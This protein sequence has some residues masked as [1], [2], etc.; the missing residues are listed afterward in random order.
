LQTPPW[1]YLTLGD[2]ALYFEDPDFV[3]L[4]DLVRLLASDSRVHPEVQQRANAVVQHLATCVLSSGSLGGSSGIIEA[5][6][7]SIYFPYMAYVRK[8]GDLAFASATH[9]DELVQYLA[10]WR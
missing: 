5:S 8:Y 1:V 10:Q 3:D 7:L 6:G 2:S 9:W 4:G